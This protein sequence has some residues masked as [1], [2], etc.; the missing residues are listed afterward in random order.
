LD[1]RRFVLVHGVWIDNEKITAIGIHVTKWVTLHGFAFNVNTDMSHF[2]LI[3]P[4]GLD[5][6]SVTS[7][8]KITGKKQDFEELVLKVVNEFVTVFG[9]TEANT[10]SL[11]EFL[12][13]NDIQLID[14]E[15]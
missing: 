5:T 4:C 9:Y 12:E 14:G 8:E 7:V 15:E 1:N 3:V 6:A 13:L 10:T 2:N 11:E